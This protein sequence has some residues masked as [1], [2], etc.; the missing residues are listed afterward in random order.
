M[1]P[2]VSAILLASAIL[3]PIRPNDA[4]AARQMEE[5]LAWEEVEEW[6]ETLDEEEF[7]EPDRLDSIREQVKELRLQPMD[8]WYSH[9]SLEASDSLRQ[10]TEQAR[11]AS[12]RATSIPPRRGSK[13]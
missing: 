1:H 12:W 13:L 5:P 2:V 11:S 9:S 10:Q 3:V 6:I 4:E 8:E 7:I